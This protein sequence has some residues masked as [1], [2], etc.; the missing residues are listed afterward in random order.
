MAPLH[1]SI[2]NV[3]MIWCQI[4]I[5]GQELAWSKMGSQ[6]RSRHQPFLTPSPSAS[7]KVTWWPKGLTTKI[8]LICL[9]MLIG[10]E[11]ASFRIFWSSIF[12]WPA[13]SPPTDPCESG[14]KSGTKLC[15][16]SQV[17]ITAQDSTCSGWSCHFDPNIKFCEK[18]T[19]P[20][21]PKNTKSGNGFLLVHTKRNI[22]KGQAKN[23]MHLL[24]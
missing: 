4:Q 12:R 18:I 15:E 3:L 21:Y 9:Q 16:R 19:G 13:Y 10:F 22:E 8:H 2:S 1:I 5:F 24:F 23:E 7:K 14:G 11:G 6:A 17:V 20:K